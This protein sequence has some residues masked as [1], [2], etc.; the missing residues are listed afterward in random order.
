MC[1]RVWVSV[2]PFRSR[3]ARQLLTTA[4]QMHHWLFVQMLR[5][6][7]TSNSPSLT[8]TENYVGAFCSPKPT[9]N[10]TSSRGAHTL[11]YA[12]CGLISPTV[13][14]LRIGSDK[15]AVGVEKLITA[16]ADAE[17]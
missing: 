15:P 8:T 14:I 17:M 4:Q 9:S 16:T 13:A 2:I 3:F 10:E 11:N 1:K 5:N 7:N 6:C 12:L